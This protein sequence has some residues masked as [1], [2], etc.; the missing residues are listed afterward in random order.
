MKNC[1]DLKLGEHLRIFILLHLPFSGLYLLTCVTEAFERKGKGIPG[2]R[3]ARK[4]WGW[5]REHRQGR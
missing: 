3:E 5:Y 2:A 1:T 4:T